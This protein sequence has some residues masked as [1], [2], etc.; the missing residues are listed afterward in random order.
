[1][2]VQDFIDTLPNSDKTYTKDEIV[3]MFKDF[4]KTHKVTGKR[5]TKKEKD[6][7]A[8]KKTPNN[9]MN[10]CNAHRE[11]FKSKNPDAK[12][13]ELTRLLGAGW[14]ELSDDE[15]AKWKSSSSLDI[16]EK[17]VEQAIKELST[18]S[19]QPEQKEE[20]KEEEKKEEKKTSRKTKK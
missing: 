1:M 18:S 14:R 5:S 13:T 20:Q 7:N 19:S 10:W 2:S 8:P 12:P 17:S 6:P 3:K 9:Y 11:E 16:L 4:M 15:K